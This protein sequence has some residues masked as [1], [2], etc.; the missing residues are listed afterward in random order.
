MNYIRGSLSAV[1]D[2]V[3]GNKRVAGEALQIS[4]RHICYLLFLSRVRLSKAI[5]QMQLVVLQ[6]TAIFGSRTK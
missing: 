1:N 2:V 5:G 3:S 6:A 4:F